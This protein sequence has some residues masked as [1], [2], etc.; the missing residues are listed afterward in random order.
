MA[1]DRRTL[2]RRQFLQMAGLAAAGGLL[3]ACGG[4]GAEEEPMGE[5][6]PGDEAPAKDSVVIQHWVFW[7]QLADC[8]E[9]WEQTDELAEALGDNTWDFK[10]GMGGDTAKTAVA[11]GTPPDVGVLGSYLD[12]MSR[13]VVIPIDDWVAGSDVINEEDFIVANWD[14]AHYEGKQYGV[15][16]YECFVRR[17]LN[18]NTRMIEEA[19]LDPDNPP[20]TWAGVYEW[21][22]ALTQFDDAGNLL[23]I[24]LDP[25]DAEGGTGPGNDGWGL[26]DSWGVEWFDPETNTFNLDNELVAEGLETMGMFIELAG[27]D[28][29]AGLRQVEGQGTWGGAYNSEV[30]AMIIEG[31][32][33]IGETM[34]EKPSVAEVNRV[35]WC[36]VPERRAGDKIQTG[37]GHM[38]QFFRDA[39]HQEEAWP[40]VEWLQ[41]DA[42]CNIVFD[43]IGWLPAYLPYLNNINVDDKPGLEFY[44]NS[45]DEATH[46]YGP[47]QCEIQAFVQQKYNEVR[48]AVYRGEMTGAEGAAQLQQAAEEE[49]EAAGFG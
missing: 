4:G 34:H 8:V 9:A 11:G 3:A 1:N 36:P 6:Q 12:Y 48:E 16:A 38:A 21:H 45:V 39:E 24:G 44:V 17:G 15:P 32:W 18:Y 30:Q 27:P 31:Y 22:E 28:N 25:Y 35:T 37:G 33:H 23:Q 29:L 41:T 47:V 5:E 2:N 42:C 26:G 46:I 13:G 10:T 43:T 19:G 20:L 14:T 40:I 7:N 49:W